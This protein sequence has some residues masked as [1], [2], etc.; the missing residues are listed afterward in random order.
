MSKR[1][2]KSFSKRSLSFESLEARQLMAADVSAVMQNGALIIA[3][4]AG[5]PGGQ[6]GVQVMQVAPGTMRVTGL[7]TDDGGVS[8]V[9]GHASQDFSGVTD[10]YLNLG[11]GNDQVVVGD[12]SNHNTTTHLAN[13]FINTDGTNKFNA[14]SYDWDKVTV[15]NLATTGTLDI[16][17][18]IG[19][20]IVTVVRSTIGINDLGNLNV[21]TG[22]GSDQ[23][24]L[25]NVTVRGSVAIFSADNTSTAADSD[26]LN[27]QTVATNGGLLINTGSGKDTLNA[28][29]V[30]AQDIIF[31]LGAGD[32]TANLNSVR[33]IDDFYARMGDGNDTL[34]ETFLRANRLTLD[35]GAGTD[36]LKTGIDGTVGLLSEVNWESINGKVPA[37]PFKK[38]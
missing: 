18:G 11:G 24:N 20:D 33:A 35:G 26:Q 28:T 25:T 4:G 13:V 19:N 22:G 21:H 6:N 9:N 27:L 29:D 17:T 8:R 15:S 1:S 3:E 38:L 16:S 23:I 14:Y 10:L 30:T 37:P 12:L 32:D 7:Q 5:W 36:S 34:K 2:R 31:D